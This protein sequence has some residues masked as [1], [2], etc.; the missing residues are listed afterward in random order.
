[1]EDVEKNESKE[2]KRGVE[3]VLVGFV[4]GDGAVDAFGV[5]DQAEYYTNLIFVEW[6]VRFDRWV[7]FGGR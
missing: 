1:M 3:N 7:L 4:A 2:H 5:F 6:G